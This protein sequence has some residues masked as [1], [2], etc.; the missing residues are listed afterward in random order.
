MSEISTIS[1]RLARNS[2]SGLVR[3]VITVPIL[4]A[5]TPYILHQLGPVVYGV[6]ALFGIVTA[7]ADLSDLGIY[8]SLARFVA[9]FW[10]AGDIRAINRSVSTVLGIYL[11]TG[12]AVTTLILFGGRF[13]VD[14]VFK[15]PASS[16]DEAIFVIAGAAIAFFISLLSGT[17]GALIMG[18]QRMDMWNAR[19]VAYTI[20]DSGGAVVVLALGYGLYGLVISRIFA[21]LVIGLVNWWTGHRIMP[22]LKV[23]PSYFNLRSA[24][25]IVGYSINILVSKI[26]SLAREPLT[27]TI[28][29]RLVSLSGVTY[30]DL[31]ARIANQARGLFAAMLAPLLPASSGIQTLGGAEAT[32][33]LYNRSTRYV[34]LALLPFF[35]GLFVLAKPLIEIWIGPQYGQVVLTLQA[36]L[37]A[38]FFAVFASPAFT[39]MEGIGLARASATSSVISAVLN[40]AL[41]VGLGVRW[42]YFG[43]LAGY[44]SSIII[45][46]VITQALFHRKLAIPLLGTLKAMPLRA[47]LVDVC[48]M[49][50]S[51]ALG[52]YTEVQGIWALLLPGGAYLIICAFGTLAFGCLDQED[53]STIKQLKAVFAR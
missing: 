28:L 15:I 47:M 16:A 36:L 53:L 17:F 27:K 43:V 33:R 49:L 11:V 46:S 14:E 25:E 52:A 35:G 50:A 22:D 44:C 26:S 39:I 30:F 40:I 13:L 29:L 2:L 24:R 3:Y 45:G 6:W 37:I 34:I 18:L 51:F 7:Y 9:Q 31:G 5:V 1:G 42:G 38:Y 32:Q 23:G 12:G 48:A 41:S 10:A 21:I 8:T 4:L 19:L 20:L